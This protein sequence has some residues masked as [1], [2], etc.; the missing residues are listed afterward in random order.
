MYRFLHTVSPSYISNKKHVQNKIIH[1]V[2]AQTHDITY[3]DI[4][5]YIDIIVSKLYIYIYIC[6]NYL[7][8]M[9]NFQSN[10]ACGGE[11]TFHP[12][13]VAVSSLDTETPNSR[14]KIHIQVNHPGVWGVKV[15]IA[16]DG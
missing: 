8:S 2:H 13:E 11:G 5:V 14:I 10:P 3:V 12:Q 15:A 6:L 16:T 9:F 7:Y 1:I 4:Y